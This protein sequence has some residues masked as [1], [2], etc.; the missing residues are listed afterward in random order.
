[1][2]NSLL[3]S[4]QWDQSK[5]ESLIDNG[6]EESLNLEYK[7]SGSLDMAEVKKKEIC[8]DVSAFANSAGGTLIYG[9]AEFEEDK[10][11]HLPERIDGIDRTTFT[12]EWLENVI[13]GIRPRISNLIIHPVELDHGEN[14]VVYVIEIPQSTTAHQSSDYK[15]YKRFNFKSV[16]MQDY[17]IR[18]VMNRQDR[19]NV[20]A[21]F[22]YRYLKSVKNIEE[23]RLQIVIKNLG[24]I[25]VNNFKLEFTF[26]SIFFSFGNYGIVN[27]PGI[28][29]RALENKDRLIGYQSKF[30]LFPNEELDISTE[31]NV[32]YPVN[33]Y[34]DSK[35][36]E[37]EQNGCEAF[38][39]WTLYADNMIPKHGKKPMSELYSFR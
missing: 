13:H 20:D 2:V 34:V 26:P 35:L 33:E 27:G 10:K 36:I 14:F 23:F 7:S 16:P 22:G 5:L 24:I 31:V 15:Y 28:K 18:D 11:K 30:V 39:S 3:Y 37:Q 9:I 17:E 25:L 19:A 21:E 4:R 8:K 1:M 38:I 6:I 32:I 29:K 12:K